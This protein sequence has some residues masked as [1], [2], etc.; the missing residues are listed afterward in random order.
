[1]TY[2]YK[3]DIIVLRRQFP[4]E[5]TVKIIADTLVLNVSPTFNLGTFS[6]QLANTYR[7]KGYNANVTY[8][9]SNTLV[10]IDKSLGGINTVPGLGQGIKVN[11]MQ[12]GNV[13]TVTYTEAEWT[14]K[15]IGLAI[16]WIICF[17]PLITAAIG[18]YSQYSLPN[19]ISADIRMIAAN[20]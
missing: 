12:N 13:L 15:I 18:A 6:E 5:R 16:G 9:G 17:I 2:T 14:S 19:N 20:L 7:G 8:L 3:Y 1:M 4:A 11:C 10:S